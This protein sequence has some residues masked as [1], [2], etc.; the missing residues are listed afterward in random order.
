MNHCEHC[1]K[2]IFDGIFID[3]IDPSYYCSEDCRAHHVSDTE[4]A[5]LQKE[6]V[7]YWTSDEDLYCDDCDDYA[8]S[9]FFWLRKQRFICVDCVHKHKVISDVSKEHLMDLDRIDDFFRLNGSKLWY[10]VP[11]RSGYIAFK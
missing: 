6:G 10:P 8:R 11:V 3:Y 7:A 2:P 5:E 9:G 1:N 4:Y